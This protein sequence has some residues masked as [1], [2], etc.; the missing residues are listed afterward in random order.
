MI[1]PNKNIYLQVEISSD[2]VNFETLTPRSPIT[3]TAFSQVANAVNGTADSSFGTTT[4]FLNTLVSMLSSATNQAVM[5]I[6]GMAGQ[7][8]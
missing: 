5:T 2:N 4:P 3:S 1:L 8:Y 6:K 7:V